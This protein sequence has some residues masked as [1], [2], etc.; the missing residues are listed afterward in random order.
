MDTAP[1]IIGRST[2]YSRPS[3]DMDAAKPKRPCDSV[4]VYL[5]DEFVGEIAVGV[6][7]RFSK[8]AKATY[9][10]PPPLKEEEAKPKDTT[11]AKPAYGPLEGPHGEVS[12]LKDWADLSEL[13]DHDQVVDVADADTDTTSKTDSSAPITAQD[14]PVAQKSLAIAVPGAWVQPKLNV[15]KH[16]LAWMEQNKRARNNEPLLPL[17]PL[18]LS[19]INLKALID[20]YTGVLAYDLAPFPH[21]LRHEI[22]TRITQQPVHAEQVRYLYEHL[23]VDD[24]IINR[25]VTSFFEHDEAE[26]YSPEERDA[27]YSYLYDEVDDEGE[28]E[29]RFSRVKRNRN[30]DKKRDDAMKIIREGF[31]DFAGA[32]QEDLPASVDKGKQAVKGDV[33][34][35]GKHPTQRAAKEDEK[36]ATQGPVNDGQRRRDRRGQQQAGKNKAK[37]SGS[38]YKAS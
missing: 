17:A 2:R 35:G 14:Q 15:A 5:Q 28:L 6:L 26:H 38:N 30:R 37:A 33:K 7:T 31:E 24:P 23:P 32:L 22:L 36:Q 3:A 21:D 8:L 34:H 19:Q 27:V 9:P 4:K 11:K 1:L 18:P 25:M 29:R 10:R 12:Q 13:A 20:T 16:I